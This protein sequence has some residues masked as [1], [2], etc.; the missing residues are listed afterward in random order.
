MLRKELRCRGLAGNLPGGRL[1]TVLA[2]LEWTWLGRLGPGAAHAHE[3]VGLILLEQDLAAENGDLFLR[4]DT[5]NGFER[6]P[7]ACRRIIVLDL[8]LLPHG[9]SFNRKPARKTR[10]VIA[11]S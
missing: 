3:S 6:A 11:S 2:E 9:I 5:G 1:G 10:D 8:C 4:E 7:A